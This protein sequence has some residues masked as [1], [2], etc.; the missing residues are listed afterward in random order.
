MIKRFG[1]LTFLALLFSAAIFIGITNQQNTIEGGRVLGELVSP[2]TDSMGQVFTDAAPVVS[3]KTS[4]SFIAGGDL[5]FD[6]YI[7]QVA[8]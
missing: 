1:F 5:M 4:L 6:R 2:E 3:K 8:N 7:R